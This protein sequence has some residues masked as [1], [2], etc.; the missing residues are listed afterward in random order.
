MPES[1][2]IPKLRPIKL[3]IKS[4]ELS[5]PKFDLKISETPIFEISRDET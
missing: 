4:S 2:N 5:T 3:E 1:L